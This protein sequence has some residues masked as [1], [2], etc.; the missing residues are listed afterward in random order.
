MKLCL[1]ILFALWLCCVPQRGNAHALDPGF[2]DLRQLG[3]GTWQILWRVP[4]VNG[5][6]MEIDAV[7]PG[8]CSPA[9]STGLTADNVAWVSTWV[10]ECDVPLAGQ[11]VSIEGLGRQRNDVLLRIQPLNGAPKTMRFTP[12]TTA[13][14]IPETPSTWSTINTYFWLG[15]QH[16]LEG[17]DHL[18]F[19]FALFIL[20]RDPWRLVGAI[21]A[22][23][24]A[25]SLT[26]AMATL[27]VLRVPSG[28]VEAIIALSIVFLA[29]EI[30]KREEGKIRLAEQYPWIVSFCFGLL[31]GLGFAGALSEIGL[32]AQDIPA[33]L[34]AFNL[35][36]EGGQLAFIAAL[37]LAVFIWRMLAPAAS[38]RLH[39]IASPTTGY[40]IG[41]VS[42]YWLVERIS[43]F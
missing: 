33:A 26:L 4:D 34:L 40:V 2:L 42:I 23:T 16:I 20:V 7:L 3:P 8:Q 39:M 18:L 36:V 38:S 25:H 10:A 22:F 31:H 37:S 28:P 41:A 1:Y 43:G 13:L 12:D 6:P 30:L 21:T 15:F 17:V 9:R 29:L 35:G 19:V 24:V 11:V 27:G 14:T 32:P 5:Q